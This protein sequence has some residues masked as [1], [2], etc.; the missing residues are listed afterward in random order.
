[1]LE[2]N[3]QFIQKEISGWIQSHYAV[4]IGS[5]IAS[6][7]GVRPNQFVLSSGTTVNLS[8]GMPIRFNGTLGGVVGGSDTFVSN[9]ATNTQVMDN[10]IGGASPSFTMPIPTGIKPA[11]VKKEKDAI[12]KVSE[13]VYALRQKRREIVTERNKK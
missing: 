13:F 6:T 1:M 12:E 11:D 3:R 10:V 8:V 5:T 7:D 9:V 4:A 2:N